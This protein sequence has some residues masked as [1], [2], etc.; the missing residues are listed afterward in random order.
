MTN[1]A[2]GTAPRSLAQA[3]S[4]RAA[5]PNRRV[6]SGGTDVMVAVNEG[7]ERPQGWL[8]L[9]RV[10]ELGEIGE[11]DGSVVIGAGC[12]FHRLQQDLTT[13]APAL[14]MAARTVG[15]P[16]IRS[17]GTIGGN[18]V[19]SSPAADSVPPLLC[20]DAEVEISSVHGE[21]TVP[22]ERFATGAKTNVLAA[23]ELVTGVTLRSTGGQEWF[24]KVGTRNAM[25][26]SVC[27]LAARLDADNGVARVAIG[28]VGP[29]VCRVVDAEVLLLDPH[30]GAEFVEA[31]TAAASPI[32]DVRATAAY[33]RHAV[34]VLAARV[35]ERLWRATGQDLR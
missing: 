12:T 27:S 25:V 30:A 13:T 28:S 32:D 4:I 21:R 34:G 6:V 9:R 1:G 16:Q 20:Y 26:I 3:L 7:R 33:R 18:L 14:A 10:A 2:T 15:G 5:E 11:R 35:H 22:L 24:S 29:T 17:A 8:S 31:V 23:D 19:T